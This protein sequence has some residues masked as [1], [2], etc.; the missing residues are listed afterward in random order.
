MST[1][2]LIIYILLGTGF[3]LFVVLSIIT[4]IRKRKKGVKKENEEEN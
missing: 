4:E 3:T 1:F 2:E